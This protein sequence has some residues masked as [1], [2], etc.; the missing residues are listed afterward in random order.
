MRI[1]ERRFYIWKN[2]S[3]LAMLLLYIWLI[4]LVRHDMITKPDKYYYEPGE[5]PPYSMMRLE[6]TLNKVTWICFIATG[7]VVF[8]WW[9]GLPPDSKFKKNIQIIQ[10]GLD[11]SK[12]DENEEGN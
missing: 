2:I 4:L 10:D 8:R 6:S 5:S 11:E 7:I 3:V 9:K 1:N 12:E